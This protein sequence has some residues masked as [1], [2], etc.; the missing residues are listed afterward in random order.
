MSAVTTRSGF[1]A[2]KAAAARVSEVLDG[3][4]LTLDRGRL[5]SLTFRDAR[6]T[7]DRGARTRRVDLTFR[8]RID[9]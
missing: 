9:I 7:R 5:V 3:A 6:A 1:A 2:A 4:R 8:A